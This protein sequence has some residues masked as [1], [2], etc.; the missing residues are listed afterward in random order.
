MVEEFCLYV[1]S[2]WKRLGLGCALV[3]LV[4]P[5]GCSEDLG[6]EGQ[7]FRCVTDA[8]CARGTV[9]HKLA[10]VC[11]PPGKKAPPGFIQGDAGGSPEKDVVDVEP[12][13]A[14]DTGDPPEADG[15][16]GDTAEDVP[17][18]IAEDIGPA[19]VT[20]DVPGE[21]SEDA[22]DAID[23]GPGCTD[24][25][26]EEG[27]F[28]NEDGLRQECLTGEDGCLTLG[29]ANACPAVAACQTT[30]CVEG[31]C[32]VLTDD[33]WCY[34]DGS[35]VESDGAAPASGGCAVCVPAATQSEWTAKEE[36]APCDDDACL[37]EQECKAGVCFGGSLKSCGDGN[38]CTDEIC[39]V[40]TGCVITPN[41]LPCDDDDAC[42]T[43]DVCADGDC[44]PGAPL[45]CEDG[46]EC[47]DDPCDAEGGCFTVPNTAPCDDGEP[48]TIGEACEGSVCTGQLPNGCDDS[49]DC[50][51]DSCEEG[52]GCV[53]VPE[54]SACTDDNECTDEQCDPADMGCSFPFNAGACDDGEPCT[55]PDVCKEGVCDGNEVVCDD[56]DACTEDSCK[57]GI[58]CVPGD[59]VDC[60]DSNACTTE[61]C[62]AATGDCEYADVVCVDGD[63]CTTDG[64]DSATGCTYTDLPCDDGLACSNDACVGG[65]CTFDTSPCD[66]LENLDC[67]DGDAC[68]VD[69]C[70]ENQCFHS[71]VECAPDALSC[72]AT[73]CVNPVVS[74]SDCAALEWAVV[75]GACGSAAL[76]KGCAGLGTYAQAV[77]A[78]EAVGARLCTWP[79]LNA[80]IPDD[81]S[82]FAV[83]DR[84]WSSSVCSATGRLT[85]PA[86]AGA[87]DMCAEEADMAQI[88]CCGDEAPDSVQ[89]SCQ[90]ASIDVG[91]CTTGPC[92]A[93]W[94]SPSAGCAQQYLCGDA[95]CS[96]I[97]ESCHDCDDQFVDFQDVTDPPTAGAC[98]GFGGSPKLY[99]QLRFT[100]GPGTTIKACFDNSKGQVYLAGI[101]VSTITIE[102]PGPISTATFKVR[103]FLN[104]SSANSQ[105]G[106][107]KVTQ[108]LPPNDFPI[109]PNQNYADVTVLFDPPVSSFDIELVEGTGYGTWI[110][111]DDI[112]YT[113]ILCP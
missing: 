14:A 11:L 86:S 29:V 107:Y 109:P 23:T 98:S 38:P 62:N 50:T 41:E 76:E 75:G 83:D 77:S 24:A 13:T 70:K 67:D 49:I 81:E 56:L 92:Q 18:E 80:G 110:G 60:D 40:E 59:V 53:H 88:I 6:L 64:C 3:V 89:G 104:N 93:A 55:G 8:D 100:A 73:A 91:G 97:D 72:T 22:P 108:A 20:E 105:F 36:G 101:K 31:E 65:D 57:P 48:C 30:G 85:A 54:D 106:I 69:G 28:C 25:C 27:F 68:T 51:V 2:T 32:P 113:S 7:L 63:P 96:D 4:A 90:T 42:T 12:D 99:D 21:T 1:Q 79:E 43:D 52:V 112:S 9:C 37:V 26:D 103:E 34:I 84:V 94:C 5:M 58:G 16:G 102:F 95:P 66:C 39:D 10:G 87:P 78:C 47:T 82:C 45:V 15:G 17:A 35:C 61:A 44:T 33:D 46:N 111:I 74:A 19:E 71:E